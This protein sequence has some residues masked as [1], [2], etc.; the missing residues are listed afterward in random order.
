MN[1]GHGSVTR[2][3]LLLGRFCVAIDQLNSDSIGSLSVGNLS[4]IAEILRSHREL[5]ALDF[6]MIAEGVVDLRNA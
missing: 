5:D 6:E 2:V 4:L 3:L 1:R